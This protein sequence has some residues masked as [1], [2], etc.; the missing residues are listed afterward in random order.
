M[1]EVLQSLL[2]EID[3]AVPDVAARD[4]LRRH[5]DD[6][7]KRIAKAD[8][9]IKQLFVDKE[10]LTQ[11]LNRTSEDLTEALDKANEARARAEDAAKAKSDFLAMMS[12]EIRT[13]MNGIIGMARLVLD[14][15]LSPE[16]RDW[17]ETISQSSDALLTILN[18]ILD[19]SKLEAGKLELETVPFDP[20][21]MLDGVVDLM[22]SR[23]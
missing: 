1:T 13:P 18:D 10:M 15:P 7:G 20:R 3:A 22:R 12:H 19:F 23:A 4:R 14:T 16:Q 17:I 8:Y 9:Q 21:R 5:V 2:S 11:L 6:L